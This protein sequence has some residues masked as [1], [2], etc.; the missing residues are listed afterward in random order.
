MV[1]CKYF[2]TCYDEDECFFQ[3]EDK[4]KSSG[5]P[6]GMDCK[7][8]SCEYGEKDHQSLKN[9]LCK[10]NRKCNRSVCPYTHAFLSEGASQIRIK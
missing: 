2:P 4:M 5:C 3:H 1:S 6:N 7:D 8:Q 9:I 10:F